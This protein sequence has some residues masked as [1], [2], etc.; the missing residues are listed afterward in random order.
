MVDFK[1]M[2]S[3]PAESVEKPK[4][5]LP[6]TYTGV[7]S[8][9]EYGESAKKKTPY[10]R[11]TMRITGVGEGV[12]ATILDGVDLSKKQLKKD[13]YLTPDAEYRVVEFSESC[14]NTRQGRTLAEMIEMCMTKPVIIGVIQRPSE[15]GTE[16][17]ND[18]SSLAGAQ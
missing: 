3:K 8:Q 7:I 17:Y 4:P 10:V 1:L 11:F 14:G 16:M 12:D 6:A 2:L 9:R 5:L 13:Y 15:D 18:V